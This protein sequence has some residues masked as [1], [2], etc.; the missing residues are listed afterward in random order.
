MPIAMRLSVVL[1]EPLRPSSP[2]TSPGSTGKVTPFKTGTPSLYERSIFSNSNT[3]FTIL[4]F[5][6]ARRP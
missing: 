1:P 4:P 3:G 6:S 2:T 5:R